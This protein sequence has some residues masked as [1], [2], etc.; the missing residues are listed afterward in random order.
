MVNTLITVSQLFGIGITLGFGS[1]CFFVCA[2][3]VLPYVAAVENH[4]GRAFADLLAL[5]GGRLLAYVLLGALAGISGEHVDKLAA[6][7]AAA[8][9]KFASGAII[10]IFGLLIALGFGQRRDMCGRLRASRL[11]KGGLALVGFAIGLAPCLPLVSV[12]FEIAIISKTPLAGAAY[13]LA[14]G[15]GTA[16]A[17]ILTVGPLAGAL[18]H[19]PSR[20]LKTQG[21]QKAFRISCGALLVL[22]GLVYVL[23]TNL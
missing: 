12:M 7:G 1:Q 17:T 18:G 21:L 4:W 13:A 3:L 2:P 5:I 19:F 20:I 22:F 8:L 23:L 15:L 6:S 11:S 9:V 16:A 14:F 10:V